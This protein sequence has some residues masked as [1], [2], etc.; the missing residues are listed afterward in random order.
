MSASVKTIGVHAYAIAETVPLKKLEAARIPGLTPVRVGKTHALFSAGE[1]RFVVVHDFGAV[2]FFGISEEER[3]S[4]MSKV[5]AIVGTQPR[6]P[7][8]ES[9]ALAIDPTTPPGSGFDRAVVP[10][11]RVEAVELVALVIGQSAAMEYYEDDV[12]KILERL[13]TIASEIAESGKPKLTVRELTRFTGEAMHLRGRVVLTLALLDAPLA[14]WNDESLD[15][16]YGE[17]RTSFAIDDRYRA[18]D[19]KLEMVRDHLGIIVDLTVQK[20]SH[21]LEIV[22][23]LLIAVEVILYVILK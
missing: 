13:D 5:V 20:R 14:T 10:A 9:F 6:P 11:L 21:V 4:V 8:E 16:V 17:L 18:L 23:A 19:D 1:E 3:Q 2:V 15:R 12:D 7:F 22:V